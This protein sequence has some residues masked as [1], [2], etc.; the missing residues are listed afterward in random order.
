MTY[1]DDLTDLGQEIIPHFRGAFPRDKI[2]KLQRG[3]SCLVNTDKSTQAGEHWTALY[4]MPN[5]TNLFYDSFG[6]PH[7]SIIPE[8]KGTKTID[9]DLKDRE[10]SF[11]S[12]N[13]GC[14]S[15]AWLMV[16]T[17]MGVDYARL[18]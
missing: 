12:F 10:Q 8:L 16:A 17:Y 18:I 4:R 2:P 1:S 11:A 9:S 3:E 6:R 14:R 13:C 5:G 7:G 15:L